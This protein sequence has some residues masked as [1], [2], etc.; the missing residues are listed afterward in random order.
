MI[1][2]YSL[3]NTNLS[4][5]L[6]PVFQGLGNNPVTMKPAPFISIHMQIVAGYGTYQ[7]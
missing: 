3:F 7:S 1:I 2:L 5:F 4:G 6:R